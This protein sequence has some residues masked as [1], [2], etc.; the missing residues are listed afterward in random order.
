MYQKLCHVAMKVDKPVGGNA[1][2]ETQTMN[3]QFEMKADFDFEVSLVEETIPSN[4]KV[5]NPWMGDGNSGMEAV[6]QVNG[7]DEA[8]LRK[9]HRKRPK[10]RT[11]KIKTTSNLLHERDERN[12][13][14]ANG[15]QNGTIGQH[16]F[17][18]RSSVTRTQMCSL[19]V[20]TTASWRKGPAPFKMMWTQYRSF[21]KQEVSYEPS[22]HCRISDDKKL[23][24]CGDRTSVTF[25]QQNRKKLVDS[26]QK[27]AET[28]LLR[29]AVTG[30]KHGNSYRN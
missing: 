5:S 3:A 17:R 28:K 22:E 30:I 16:E 11:W 14:I 20:P 9:G 6:S 27:Q 7:I 2:G 21:G 8:Q 13:L 23:E 24:F 4:K 26:I 29:N 25:Y 12:Q 15:I 1:K 18:D 19:K 10:K